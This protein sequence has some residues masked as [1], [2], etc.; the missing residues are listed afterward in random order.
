MD[1]S[2]KTALVTGASMG[3]GYEIAK[4]LAE[5]NIDLILVA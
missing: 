2:K 4:Q 1:N 5:K 3:I